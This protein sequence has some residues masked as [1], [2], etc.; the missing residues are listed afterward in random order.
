MDLCCCEDVPLCHKGLTN[1]GASII[2]VSILFFLQ[3]ASFFP[4]S[5]DF[6]FV[7][8]APGCLPGQTPHAVQPAGPQLGSGCGSLAVDPLDLERAKVPL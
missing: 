3:R 8:Y 7:P 1:T 2:P 4:S 5:L 6:N